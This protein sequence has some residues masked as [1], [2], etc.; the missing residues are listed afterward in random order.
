ML[1]CPINRPKCT[2]STALG[3]AF[4]SGLA[5]GVWESTDELKKVRCTE[6][7]F[8]S[9]I[10]DEKRDELYNGW[11]KSVKMCLSE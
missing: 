4:L 10:S 8:T 9:K 7:V 6:K 1:N 5:T 11:I 2:E 3:A